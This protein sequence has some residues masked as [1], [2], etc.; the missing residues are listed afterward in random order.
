M[1]AKKHYD[2]AKAVQS[3]QR[4]PLLP[5]G[6]VTPLHIKIARTLALHGVKDPDMAKAFGVS[7]QTLYNWKRDSHE[8]RVAVYEGRLIHATP[9]FDAM[10]KLASGKVKISSV[11]H[12]RPNEDG[13]KTITHVRDVPPSENA[14]FGIWKLQH[15]DS[16]KQEQ[17]VVLDT[18][19]SDKEALLEY[20]RRLAQAEADEAANDDEPS[21]EG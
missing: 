16:F 8:F 3:V 13:S 11:T 2:K 1:A 15:P 10:K 18:A 12:I 14:A 17:T 4:E 20:Q 19:A 6:G 21:K 5:K 7:E 9:I